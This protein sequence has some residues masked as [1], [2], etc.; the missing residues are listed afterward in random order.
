MSSRPRA[1]LCEFGL[2]FV[3]CAF[4]SLFL[5]LPPNFPNFQQGLNATRFYAVYLYFQNGD[6]KAHTL[7][8]YVARQAVAGPGIG[9]MQ[10]L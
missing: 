2:F 4:V 7:L 9:E 6:V 8:L 3:V 5:S 10:L 1:G